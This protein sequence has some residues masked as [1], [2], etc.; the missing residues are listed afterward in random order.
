[1]RSV[2]GGKERLHSKIRDRIDKQGF[3]RLHYIKLARN[4]A[5]LVLLIH[6]VYLS[7]EA[8]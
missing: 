7:N 1:M 6:L 5:T 4:F 2:R 3:Q 8:C